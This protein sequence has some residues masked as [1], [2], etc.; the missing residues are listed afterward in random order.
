MSYCLHHQRRRQIFNSVDSSKPLTKY[1]INKKRS[2]NFLH[3][4]RLI[5]TTGKTFSI[6]L[7]INF[8]LYLP[9]F[10]LKQNHIELKWYFPNVQFFY[11][12]IS[13]YFIAL[14]FI[15][16]NLNRPITIFNHHESGY[17]PANIIKCIL[18]VSNLISIFN[19]LL[20]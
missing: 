4:V 17:E 19:V 20:K 5:F 11:K 16:N 14:V 10:I 13:F 6:S 2:R 7:F 1:P 9:G 12:P 18:L 8:F 3:E 15:K